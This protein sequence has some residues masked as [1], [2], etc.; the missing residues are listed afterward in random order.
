MIQN[1]IFLN[2]IKDLL[3]CMV[4]V[5]AQSLQEN[6]AIFTDCMFNLSV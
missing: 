6:S 1:S 2:N 3:F 5:V 4:R